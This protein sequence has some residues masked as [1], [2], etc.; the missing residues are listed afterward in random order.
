MNLKNG[1]AAVPAAGAGIG[2][3]GRAEGSATAPAAQPRKWRRVLGA[4]LDGRTLNRF[5][6]ARELRDHVLPTTVSQLEQRG[7]T[8]LRKEETIPG[9]FGPVRCARYWLD[10][11]SRVRALELLD[12]PVAASSA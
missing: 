9:A 1:P 7:L 12:K 11:A 10:P 2:T 3:T 4:L 5:E 6:A 8:I